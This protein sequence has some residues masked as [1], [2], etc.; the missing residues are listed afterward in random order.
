MH[1]GR[2][3]WWSEIHRF[4]SEEHLDKFIFNGMRDGYDVDD[5]VDFLNSDEEVEGVTQFKIK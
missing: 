5:W 2:G 1:D 4:D 3:R